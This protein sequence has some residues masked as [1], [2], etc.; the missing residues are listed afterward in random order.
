[1]CR[2]SAVASAAEESKEMRIA[3]WIFISSFGL[4][5]GFGAAGGLGRT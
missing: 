2:P 4:K 1:V 5:A 3:A